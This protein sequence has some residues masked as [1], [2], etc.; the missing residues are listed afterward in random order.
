MKS[1][2]CNRG[3]ILNKKY[4]DKKI[5]DNIK[6]ELF[7]TPF[8]I[9]KQFYVS[10]FKLYLENS[11]QICIPKYYGIK[12]LGEVECND[13]YEGDDINCSFVGTLREYQ[14][15]IFKTFITKFKKEKGGILSIPPGKGKTVMGIYLIS[16]LKKKT[17]IIVHKSFLINQ[18]RKRLEQYLPSSKIGEIRQDKIDIDGKDVV[19]GML[20]SIS[21]K[22]YDLEIFEDFGFCIIDEVHHLGAEVFSRALQ[23]INSDYMLGLSATPFREDKLEKVIYWYI[24]DILYL[25]KASITQTIKVNI[26]NYSINHKL[27]CEVKNPRTMKAQMST[28]ISNII[29]IT[30]RT[31]IFMDFLI[32]IKK[33][34]PLRKVL[35]LSERLGHL[36]EM[37]NIIDEKTNYTTS[38]YIGGMK[39]K[40]L[41]EAEEA[42]IIFSTYQMSSEGLDIP[43]L[44]TILLTTSRKNVEQ[45]VGRILRKQGGQAVF[46]LIIDF[47]DNIKQFKNQGSI[48]KRY[49]KKITEEDNISYY[50]NK[51]NKFVDKNSSRIKNETELNKKPILFINDD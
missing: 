48:R 33:K 1:I 23:K 50:E 30:E 4:F 22:D 20:Q 29:E 41:D 27:F 5:I 14:E 6:K 31:K 7:V 15:N 16:I 26:C 51:D 28:M 12:K 34:E 39:E 9:D 8:T 37:K 3:Y 43:T 38:K 35:V 13:I 42:E 17:L 18:W 32:K 19:I 25:E 24:G 10:G 36:E 44:N 47:V 21:M 40:K 49:Y 45:S 2:L 46:P 11:K